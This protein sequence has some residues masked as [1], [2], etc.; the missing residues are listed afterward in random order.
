MPTHCC[1]DVF[2]ICETVITDFYFE[3]SD[4]DQDT[5]VPTFSSI[6]VQ[7]NMPHLFSFIFFSWTQTGAFISGDTT[8]ARMHQRILLSL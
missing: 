1:Q 2:Y 3:N 8:S 7:V 5:E 4:L 6:Q